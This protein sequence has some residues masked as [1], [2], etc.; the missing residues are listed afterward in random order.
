MMRA[1]AIVAGSPSPSLRSDGDLLATTTVLK[2]A[3]CVATAAGFG[4]DL[5]GVKKDDLKKEV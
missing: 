2:F 1:I 4:A 5:G 3:D